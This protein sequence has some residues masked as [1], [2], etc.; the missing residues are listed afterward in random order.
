MIQFIIKRLAYGVLVVF[1]VTLIISSVI[2][3]APVDPAR[4]TFGQRSD[5]ESVK[6]K[7]KELGLDQPL[8][9]QL[10]MYLRDISPLAVHADTKSNQEKYNFFRL[11]PLGERVLVL[12]APYLRESFQ[13]GAPVSDILKNA[14]PRTAILA[15]SAIFLATVIGISLG[16]ISPVISWINFPKL[17]SSCG[18][19]PTTV[20]GQMAF[21]L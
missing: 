12:K 20:K 21:F 10:L 7:Q 18:G 13:T 17:V 4:L 14:I 5:T 15:L 3:L 1:L 8:S 9:I 19:R 2:Y 16:I 11:I 6:A